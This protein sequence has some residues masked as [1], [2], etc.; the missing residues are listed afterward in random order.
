MTFTHNI[1]VCEAV[2]TISDV[3][4]GNYPEGGGGGGAGGLGGF[5]GGAGDDG[6]GELAAA[7]NDFDDYIIMDPLTYDE[8]KN[9][10]SLEERLESIISGAA[11]MA[12]S[13][14][15]IH[16]ECEQGYFFITIPVS[17]DGIIL[18]FQLH[19]GREERAYRGRV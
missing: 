18:W 16:L 4:K 7:L 10:P 6:P 1:Q 9:R 8:S 15:I 17:I 2:N 14:Y 5:G 13:R 11:L 19:K 3:A 12:D